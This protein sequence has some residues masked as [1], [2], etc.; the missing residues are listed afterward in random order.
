MFFKHKEWNMKGKEIRIYVHT[1]VDKQITQSAL[2]TYF[3][4]VGQPTR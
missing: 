4:W 2:N 1:V 3:I